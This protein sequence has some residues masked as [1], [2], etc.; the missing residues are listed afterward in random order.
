VGTILAIIERAHRGAVEQQYAHVLWLVHGL[1]RQSP[2]TVLLRGTAAVYA[3]DAEPPPRLRL[4]GAELVHVPDYRAAMDRLR[5]DGATVLV[6]AECL[7]RVRS[8]GAPLL[9]GVTPVTAAEIAATAA[10][11]DRIWYL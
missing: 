11:C 3:L 1:H 4:G 10:A 2:M 7:D 9:P 5:T 6:S 8:P